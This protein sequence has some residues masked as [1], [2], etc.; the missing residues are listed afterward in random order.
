VEVVRRAGTS[1]R[2]VAFVAEDGRVRHFLATPVGSLIPAGRGEERLLALLRTLNGMLEASP[3]ARRR[4][5]AFAAP[6]LIPIWPQLRLLEDDPSC[7]SYGEAYEIN[8]ARHARDPDLPIMLFKER[9]NAAAAGALS[10]DAVLDLR[11]ATYGEIASNVVSE[12]LF[13]QYM[14]NSLPAAHHLWAFKRTLC[15]QT[16]LSAFVCAALRIGGRTPHKLLFSRA[17]GAVL[18]ADFYPTFDSAGSGLCQSGEPVPFRLT[19]NLQTFF[20]PFGVEGVFVTTLAAAAAAALAPGSAFDAHL[21]LFMRDQ[22]SLW[23]WRR[24]ATGGGGGVTLPPVAEELQALVELNC[25]E[26]LHGRLAPLLPTPPRRVVT[27]EGA[28]PSVQ[29]GASQLVDAAVDPKN[30]CRMDPTY[31]AWL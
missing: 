17:S 29:R 20:T 11:L 25:A 7:A 3:E 14:Y 21:H 19:R 15:A 4:G 6:A 22:I 16:A 30:L 2:R 1:H 23:P 9:L 31:M 18:Q 12:N 26:V 27:P 5:L 24:A 10:G 13:S 28:C 8:C